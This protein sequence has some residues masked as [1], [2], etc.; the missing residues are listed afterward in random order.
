VIRL[1][2]VAAV[3]LAVP[4]AA[5]AMGSDV[6]IDLVAWNGDGSAALLRRAT[7]RDGDH[8]TTFVVVSADTTEPFEAAISATMR[9][10]GV[11]VEQLEAAACE[12]AAGE[13][14]RT[15]AAHHFGT[16]A[17]RPGR[18]RTRRRDEVVF[19]GPQP[20]Q[21]P[22]FAI[23]D[24]LAPECE[25]L[26]VVTRTARLILVFSTFACGSPTK[27]RVQTFVPVAGGFEPRAF[28]S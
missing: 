24:A 28:V 7:S 22:A 9:E 23:P 12:T 25:Q 8:S 10:P 16:V 2:I 26:E 19:V 14:Q 5:H 15:L 11:D 1:A 17:V 20:P 27:M 3:V 6:M 4:A 21:L 18:C 13:L